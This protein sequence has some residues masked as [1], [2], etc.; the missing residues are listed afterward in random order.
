MLLHLVGWPG[1]DYKSVFESYISYIQTNFRSNDVIVVFDGYDTNSSIQQK[2]LS[3]ENNK[4]RFFKHLTEYLTRANIL[5]KQAVDD[6]DFLIVSTDLDTYSY[7]I[8]VIIAN[9]TD[10]LV[11]LI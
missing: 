9:D 10:I 7:K 3:N 8:P 11:L 5:V 6:A 2:F 1:I 4:I